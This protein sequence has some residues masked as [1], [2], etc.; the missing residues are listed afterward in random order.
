MKTITFTQKE[1][2]AKITK[3]LENACAYHAMESWKLALANYDEAMA[4]MDMLE[5]FGVYYEDN[6]VISEHVMAMLE[7]LE[8]NTVF[9]VSAFVR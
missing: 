3:S 1:I 9:V 6:C 5:E 8:D 4:Y 2:E 7:I